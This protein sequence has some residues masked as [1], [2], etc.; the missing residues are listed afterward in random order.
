MV[1]LRSRFHYRKPGIYLHLIRAHRLAE[2]ALI[3]EHPAYA[4][5]R[6][7]VELETPIVSTSASPVVNDVDFALRRERYRKLVHA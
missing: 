6:T 5:C 2:P 3:P 1:M 4:G 7:W